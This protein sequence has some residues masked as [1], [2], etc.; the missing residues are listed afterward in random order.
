M[1][2]RKKE[3]SIEL[4]AEQDGLDFGGMGVDDDQFSLLTK[5]FEKFLKIYVGCYEF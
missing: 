5:N 4:Q 3:N 2:Q 1:K